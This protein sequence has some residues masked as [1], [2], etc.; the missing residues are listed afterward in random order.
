MAE[1][2]GKLTVLKNKLFP[3]YRVLLFCLSILYSPIIFSSS[4]DVIGKSAENFNFPDLNNKMHSL[5]GLNNKF[6]IINFWATWCVPCRKEI[7]LLNSIY[8]N[9]KSDGIE[10]IGIAIDNSGA[11]KKFVNMIPINYLNLIGGTQASETILSYGNISGVLPYTVF[12][13][14]QNKIVVVAKGELTKSFLLRTI[15]K[16]R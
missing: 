4:M 6:I 9:H 12:I 14:R 13:N 16:Y 5:N 15:K 11:V 3:Q 7:P 8:T 1:Y 2:L 10:V